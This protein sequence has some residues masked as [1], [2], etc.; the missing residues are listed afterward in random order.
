MTLEPISGRIPT[1]TT[2][3]I[4]KRDDVAGT[5]ASEAM[6]DAM[7]AEHDWE[8]VAWVPDDHGQSGSW[9]RRPAGFWLLRRVVTT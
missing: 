8:V 6:L 5:P 4:Y 3:H 1:R 9:S 7:A 2:E